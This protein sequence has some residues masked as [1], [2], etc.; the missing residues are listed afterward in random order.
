VRIL[1]ADAAM[2]DFLVDLVEPDRVA[3]LPEIAF[4]YSALAVDPGPW[5]ERPRFAAYSGEEVLALAPDLV[6]AHD[7]ADPAT[8]EVLVRSGVPLMAPPIPTDLEAV[9]AELEAVGRAVWEPERAAELAADALARAAALLEEGE[10]TGL[11]VLAYSNYGTGVWSAG[12][13]TTWDEMIRLAGMVNAAADLEGNVELENEQIIAMQP[14]VF[15]CG[16]LRSTPDSSTSAEL[17]R[18][19][20]A[21]AHLEAVREGRIVILPTNLYG[22]CSHRL[23][24]AAERLAAAVDALLAA[25]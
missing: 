21:L 10:R 5:A 2:T 25:E 8:S 24:E 13:G 17:L 18:S 1:P 19:D 16:A 15:L 12:S 20:P 9:L 11:R 23:V 4:Q 14:D 3:A 22:T 7:L 6:L